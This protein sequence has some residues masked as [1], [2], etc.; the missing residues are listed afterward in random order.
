MYALNRKWVPHIYI[1]MYM[2]GN[3]AIERF[4]AR[5]VVDGDDQVFGRE[6]K[7]KFVAVLDMTSGKVLMAANRT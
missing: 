5:L 6:Y 3:G 7:L 4:K 1:Y 2:D